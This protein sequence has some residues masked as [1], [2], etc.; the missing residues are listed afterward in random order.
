MNT[1]NSI[2]SFWNANL[3]AEKAPKLLSGKTVSLPADTVTDDFHADE[4]PGDDM[5]EVIEYHQ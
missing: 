3:S 4:S 2:A 5:L 1:I